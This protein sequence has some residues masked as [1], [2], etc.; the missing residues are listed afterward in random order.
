MQ[1][2]ALT[3][4]GAIMAAR[5]GPV[6]ESFDQATRRQG[7][8]TNHPRCPPDRAPLSFNAPMSMGLRLMPALI[9]PFRLAC[10]S[11][12]LD[13][14]LTNRLVDNVEESCDLAITISG[15]P[16]DKST[17]RRKI[18]EVPRHAIAAPSLLNA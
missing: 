7:D 13:V 16:K 5:F 9:N 17:F 11:I 2:V 15:P 6:V 14:T 8:Q 1:Q 3:R 18:S 10:P 12:P 4:A